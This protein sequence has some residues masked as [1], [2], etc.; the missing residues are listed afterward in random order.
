MDYCFLGWNW[1]CGAIA[2]ATL[3]KEEDF[4]FLTILPISPMS[5][6]FD[7]RQSNSQ[8]SRAGAVS[9]SITTKQRTFFLFSF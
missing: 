4:G 8:P 5:E 9:Q 6:P 7:N 1:D 3:R 2:G